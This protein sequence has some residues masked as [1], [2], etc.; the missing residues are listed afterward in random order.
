MQ[1]LKP[2]VCPT[3]KGLG[4]QTCVCYGEK[5][6]HR[7]R[8]CGGGGFTDCRRCYGDRVIDVPCYCEN[9]RTHDGER[10]RLISN[11]KEAVNKSVQEELDRRARE[12]ERARNQPSPPP[13]PID[14]TP[15]IIGRAIAIIA[16]CVSLWFFYAPRNIYSHG[17]ISPAEFVIQHILVATLPSLMA[18]GVAY[19]FYRMILRSHFLQMF[20]VGLIVFDVLLFQILSGSWAP[21]DNLQAIVAFDAILLIIGGLA[22]LLLKARA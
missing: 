22:S 11:T 9:Y 7:C 2:I 21:G 13:I 1:H 15:I 19:L 18:A 10:D 6:Q 8:R 17:P 3:C 4:T 20:C 14:N 12:R 16:F 5:W